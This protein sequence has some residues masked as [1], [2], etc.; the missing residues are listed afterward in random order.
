[1]MPPETTSNIELDEQMAKI[2]KKYHI[3]LTF[4]KKEVKSAFWKEMI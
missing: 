1:M 4:L 2:L 3:F